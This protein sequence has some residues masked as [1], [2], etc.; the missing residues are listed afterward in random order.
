VRLAFLALLLTGCATSV[1]FSPPAVDVVWGGAYVVRCSTGVDP[2]TNEC[3]GGAVS[4]VRGD[5]VSSAF[6]S[7]LGKL[8]D[9]GASFVG[10]G[11]PTDPPVVN[12]LPAG[13]PTCP[14][15]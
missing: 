1:R 13:E 9:A 2:A 12:V 6:A 10:A 3:L 5:Y 14:S 4:E 8:V 11:P 7:W 15:P